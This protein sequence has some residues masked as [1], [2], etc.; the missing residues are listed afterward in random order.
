MTTYDDSLKKVINVLDDIKDEYDV[1]NSYLSS[2][3]DEYERDPEITKEA[4]E[5]A[6]NEIGKLLRQLKLAYEQGKEL[7]DELDTYRGMVL[8]FLIKYESET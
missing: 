7:R 5:D 4:Y 6:V 1:I 3:K 8:W 2:L